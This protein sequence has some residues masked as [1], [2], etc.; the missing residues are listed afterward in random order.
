MIR[1]LSHRGT[2]AAIAAAA[3][4]IACIGLGALAW[5]A[6]H[7]TA[8]LVLFIVGG[9]LLLLGGVGAITLMFHEGEPPLATGPDARADRGGVANAGG[10][11]SIIQQAG[12]G[13]VNV[14]LTSNPS[15]ID[16]GP[17]MLEFGEP[18]PAPGTPLYDDAGTL[19]TN[20]KLWRVPL[21]NVARGTKARG[22]KV[23]I[24]AIAPH[25]PVIPVELHK[26]H[27]DF[28]PFS[29]DHDVR[30]G[31]PLILDIV[32][33]RDGYDEFFLW[34]SDLPAGM[35]YVYPLST[36]ELRALVPALRADGVLV[37]LR[38]V[39]DP[40]AEIAQHDYRLRIDGAGEFL[41]E[42]V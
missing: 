2:S 42:P 13:N 9:L 11:G 26:F 28:P 20:V 39:P 16:P 7:R 25:L 31:D 5:R 24:A 12:T 8:A 34:R 33:K 35:G 18:R 10:A 17:P 3:L 23:E 19:I 32:A 40:P 38:A 4:G 37:T 30:F 29:R 22:V 41:M 27:D 21:S 1:F 6:D 14:I 15:P 36:P